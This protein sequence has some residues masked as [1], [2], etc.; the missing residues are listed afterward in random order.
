M[1]VERLRDLGHGLDEALLVGWYVEVGDAVYKDQP[2]A[3]LETDKATLEYLCSATGRVTA[4]LRSPGEIIR[5][6]DE[7]LTT[8]TV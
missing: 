2:I 4:L 6:G 1:A 8:T 7:L 3:E 5:V